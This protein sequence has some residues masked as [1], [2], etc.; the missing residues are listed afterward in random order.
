MYHRMAQERARRT[1][2]QHLREER[3]AFASKRG[4]KAVRPTSARIIHRQEPYDLRRK[5]C[6]GCEECKDL[7]G[8]IVDQAMQAGPDR[9]QRLARCPRRRY[10]VYYCVATF[11]FIT[12]RYAEAKTDRRVYQDELDRCNELVEQG[13][14]AMQK[15]PPNI[16]AWAHRLRRMLNVGNMG[17][18]GSKEGWSRDYEYLS[19]WFK[20]VAKQH[21]AQL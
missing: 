8:L 16:Q 1:R 15:L 6:T 20:Q 4:D 13:E 14:N 10:Y 9:F 17:T 12:F 18:S 19:T 7:D 2:E 3:H 5:W 21:G 11:L